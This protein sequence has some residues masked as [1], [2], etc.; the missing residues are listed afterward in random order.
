MSLSHSGFSRFVLDTDSTYAELVSGYRITLGIVAL[1]KIVIHRALTNPLATA[2]GR[3][4][5]LCMDHRLLIWRSPS[6]AAAF[7][8]GKA[9]RAQ[10]IVQPASAT[11]KPSL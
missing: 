8:E 5:G 9:N 11:P 10:M 7:V 6:T 1:G 2:G 4:T 3:S